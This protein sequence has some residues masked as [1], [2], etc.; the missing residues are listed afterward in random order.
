MNAAVLVAPA[1]R[2][3]EHCAQCAHYLAE[4]TLHADMKRG[5]LDEKRE[6]R[7]ILRSHLLNAYL[8][9]L[10][11]EEPVNELSDTNTTNVNIK[12]A[13][14]KVAAITTALHKSVAGEL[15]IHPTLMEREIEAAKDR[16]KKLERACRIQSG[17]A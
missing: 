4:A 11:A 14:V 10:W 16:L 13:Y 3:I 1:D 5:T 8:A 2:V 6:R 17:M 15:L 12:M 7:K 9:M